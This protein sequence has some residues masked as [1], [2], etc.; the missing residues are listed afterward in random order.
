MKI[1]LE[2]SKMFEKKSGYKNLVY[3]DKEFTSNFF[4]F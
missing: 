3:L 1:S 4:F 2:K